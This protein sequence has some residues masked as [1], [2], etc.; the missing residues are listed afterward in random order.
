VSTTDHRTR[1]AATAVTIERVEGD[2]SECGRP[3]TFTGTDLFARVDTVLNVWRQS[4]PAL[5]YHKYDLAVRFADG[6]TIKVQLELNRDVP[7]D[8]GRELYDTAAAYVNLGWGPQYSEPWQS[9]LDN[10]QLGD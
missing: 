10:Y 6:H 8:S 5:G 7:I 2:N 4:A 9:L 3:L 1:I